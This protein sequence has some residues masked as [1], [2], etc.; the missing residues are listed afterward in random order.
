MNKS[1]K[2]KLLWISA[3]RILSWQ[4]Y[5]AKTDFD[6]LSTGPVDVYGAGNQTWLCPNGAW[7]PAGT[8]LNEESDGFFFRYS[9]RLYHLYGWMVSFQMADN[10]SR[11]SCHFEII[12]NSLWPGDAI[13]RHRS[14]STLSQVMAC[15]LTAPSHYLNQCW[16]II[17][18]VLW[19]S[20]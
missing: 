14:G 12:F 1:S 17:C 15:C 20:P 2:I 5:L 19:H 18:E 4:Y 6:P 9:M 7:P 8:V 10:I 11:K 13:W 16:L 3:L